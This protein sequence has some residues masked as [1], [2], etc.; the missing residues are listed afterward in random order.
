MMKAL[1]IIIWLTAT[2]VAASLSWVIAGV[3]MVFP[4]KF[5]LISTVFLG[6]M[7]FS[8]LMGLFWRDV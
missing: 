7:L 2:L 6:E 5:C 1:I 4:A 3:E 8:V